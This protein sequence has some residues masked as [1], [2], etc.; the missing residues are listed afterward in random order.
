MTMVHETYGNQK[1]WFSVVGRELPCKIYRTGLSLA[2]A[3]KA[4]SE[5]KAQVPSAVIRKEQIWD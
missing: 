3:K 4:L 1:T 5:I 2:D